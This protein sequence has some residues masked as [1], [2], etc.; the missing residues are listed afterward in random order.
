MEIKKIP[1]ALIEPNNG[2]IP[3]LPKNPRSWSVRELAKLKASIQETPELVEVRPP[4]VVKHGDKFIA[5]GGNMRLAALQEL[6]ETSVSVI[7]MPED[8]PLPKLK[9]VTIKD[10]SKF[11]AWDFDALANEWG[12]YDLAD[13]G[14]PVFDDPEPSAPGDG[15]A[16]PVDDRVVIEIEFTPDE[17]TFI[18]NKLRSIGDTMENAVLKALHL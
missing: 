9:A 12:D 1:I 8:T 14:I 6:G 2:Q 4:I 18:T 13:Y 16:K 7:V 5:I 3:G 15:N 10:N 11:G 17:F